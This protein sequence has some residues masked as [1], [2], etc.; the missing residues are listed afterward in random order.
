MSEGGHK[1]ERGVR[2]DATL[3]DAAAAQY[4]V[5]S[6]DQLRALGLGARAVQQRARAGRLHRIHRGVYSPVPPPLLARNGLLLAAV[7]ACGPEAVLSHESAALLHGIHRPNIKRGDID[8][9]AARR[10]AH[11]GI[12]VH[13]SGTLTARDVTRVQRIPCTTIA[14]TLLDL[15]EVMVEGP[16][17]SALNEADASRR[18]DLHA[19][20]D[21][22]QRNA[23]RTGAKRLR[24]ALRLYQPRQAPPESRL[25]EDFLRRIRAAGLPEPRR[26]VLLDLEDGEPAFRV[27]FMWPEHRAVV[28][29]DGN[30]YHG[31]RR[32]FEIDRRR[33][34]RLM[35]AGWRFARITW[36]QLRDDPGTV[37]RVVADLLAGG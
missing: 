5:L 14:R 30:E 32:A 35:Q 29:T 21:Q 28:E 18:L 16:L 9:T 37:I 12:T 13:R 34:Q 26:Q 6:L 3:A 25:E 1:S 33:D 15:A 20:D 10:H 23:T 11:H 27:D 2:L 36:R 22:L 8:I 24:A 7:L 4:G 19:I 17:E 31:T